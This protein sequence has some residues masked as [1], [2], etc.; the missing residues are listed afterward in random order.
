MQRVLEYTICDACGEERKTTPV[1]ISVNK[2]RPY[3]L[4]ICDEHLQMVYGLMQH[5]RQL[6]RTTALRSMKPV[7]L[8]EVEALRHSNAKTSPSEGQKRPS[9]RS[10]PRPST[11]D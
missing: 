4:D 9:G 6:R 11:K 8:D 5:G 10:K 1:K 2:K 3:Q 7:T